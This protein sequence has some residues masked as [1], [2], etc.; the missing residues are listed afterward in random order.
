MAHGDDLSARLSAGRRFVGF[1]QAAL[2]QGAAAVC[3][4]SA[5]PPR[6]VPRAAVPHIRRLAPRLYYMTEAAPLFRIFCHTLQDRVAFI[7]TDL[8]QTIN[9]IRKRVQDNFIHIYYT[10]PPP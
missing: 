8:C 1:P 4:P 3:P 5:A 10:P 6:D 7:H 2:R 9:K